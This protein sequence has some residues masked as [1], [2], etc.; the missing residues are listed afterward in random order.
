MTTIKRIAAKNVKGRTF[1]YT[2]APVTVFSGANATGKTA[3]ADA[4]RVGLTGQHSKLGKRDLTKLAGGASMSIAVEFSNGKFSTHE[5]AQKAGAWKYKGDLA[6]GVPIPAVLLDASAYFALTS[7]E[8]I[9]FIFRLIPADKVGLTVGD[10]VA[11]LNRLPAPS[12]RVVEAR[13][14]LE[15]EVAAAFAGVPLA[16]ALDK[17]VALCKKAKADAD[18][19]AKQM[20]ASILAQMQMQATEGMVIARNVDGQM[21]AARESV[22]SLTVKLAEL[23][24]EAATSANAQHRLGQLES[25]IRAAQVATSLTDD[26]EADVASL[27]DVLEAMPDGAWEAANANLARARSEVEAFRRDERSKQ[28][29]WEEATERAERAAKQAEQRT[30][31]VA[32]LAELTPRIEDAKSKVTVAAQSMAEAAKATTEARGFVNTSAANIRFAMADAEQADQKLAELTSHET[33]P[34]CEASETGWKDKVVGKLA[35]LLDLRKSTLADALASGVEA[36]ARLAN[37]TLTEDAATGAHKTGFNSLRAFEDR[38]RQIEGTLAGLAS[39]GHEK[40]QEELDAMA[41]EIAGLAL[42]FEALTLTVDVAEQVQ[43]DATKERTKRLATR[44]ALGKAEARLL[45]AKGTREKLAVL[46]AEAETFGK[47]PQADEENLML[48]A[49]GLGVAEALVKSLTDSTKRAAAET[50]DAKRREQARGEAEE[51]KGVADFA[52]AAAEALVT[53]QSETIAHA[54]GAVLADAQRIT[55]GILGSPLTYRDGEIGRVED[56]VFISHLTFSGMEERLAYAA[57]QVALAGPDNALKLVMV[58][59]LGTLDAGNKA[60]LINRMLDLTTEGLV[61]QFIGFDVDA[62]FYCAEEHQWEDK[63]LQVTE[64]SGR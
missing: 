32:E 2:L 19:V 47:V 23:R 26:F 58:D 64:I 37:A 35:T 52:K 56:G 5:W 51:V 63:G 57:L 3:I 8:R 61:G 43:A 18:A 53:M 54:F 4:I 1:D 15:K 21:E 60:A 38:A 10:V 50:Q 40:S 17:S 14:A 62:E 27:R 7:D 48:A 12:A 34:W 55:E 25:E 59:E 31:L 39:P 33:C 9:K 13:V 44:D 36:N 41:A 46:M 6:V 24:Q 20:T 22:A 45:A 29:A 49:E 11:A 30:R 42:P 16:D 28:A